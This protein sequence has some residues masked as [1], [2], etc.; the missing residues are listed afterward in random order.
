MRESIH[1]TGYNNAEVVERLLTDGSKVYDVQ[2]L[3]DTIKYR[4]IPAVSKEGAEA[5]AEVINK[6][7]V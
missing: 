3:D 5:M 4:Y 2:Y 6:Y 7:S 1:V